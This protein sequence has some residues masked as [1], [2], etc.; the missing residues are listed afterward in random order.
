MTSQDKM[1]GKDLRAL[2]GFL[3]T[4]PLTTPLTVGILYELFR[5]EYPA[6]LLGSVLKDL[7]IV[8]LPP[9]AAITVLSVGPVLAF[10][11]NANVFSRIR[12][13]TTK[14]KCD[15]WVSIRRN[16]MNLAVLFLSLILSLVMVTLLIILL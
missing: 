6:N 13:E 3:L 4:M 11:F 9:W 10:Y 7:G 12:F 16:W 2:S 14:E 8:Y 15:C 1:S 5:W